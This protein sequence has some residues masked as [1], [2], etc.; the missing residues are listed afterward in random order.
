MLKFVTIFRT[1]FSKRSI[2]GKPLVEYKPDYFRLEQIAR[3]WAKQGGLPNHV[4]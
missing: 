3:G 4:D 2:S 1:S